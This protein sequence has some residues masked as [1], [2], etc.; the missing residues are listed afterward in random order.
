MGVCLLLALPPS[1]D[2]SANANGN[3]VS[4]GSSP[5]CGLM[6]LQDTQ[7]E[8]PGGRLGEHGAHQLG[9]ASGKPVD[10]TPG[11]QKRG[12]M[13]YQPVPMLPNALRFEALA[14]SARDICARGA[15]RCP[16]SGSHWRS[17]PRF[18]WPG[19]GRRLGVRP[20]APGR[21][22]SSAGGPSRPDSSAADSASATPPGPGRCPGCGLQP[23]FWE[24]G[25]EVALLL[26]YS[27]N[28]SH[29]S[30]EQAQMLDKLDRVGGAIRGEAG[31]IE[32]AGPELLDHVVG[33]LHQFLVQSGGKRCCCGV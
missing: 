25:K 2:L 12:K 18:G 14:W 33:Q 29:S 3:I 32:N 28:F 15:G 19:T 8:V 9:I 7:P 1:L 5:K 20:P 4:C 24:E 26:E 6:H 10:N 11:R 30:N 23:F 27:P 21:R 22:P 17:W 16:R 13:F 31:A